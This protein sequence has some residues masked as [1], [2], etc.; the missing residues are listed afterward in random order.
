MCS[1]GQLSC[2]QQLWPSTTQSSVHTHRLAM[3]NTS[4]ASQIPEPININ[5]SKAIK[6]HGSKCRTTF[7]FI[8]ESSVVRIRTMSSSVS[9]TALQFS[10]GFPSVSVLRSVT[11]D[12]SKPFSASYFDSV[13]SSSS[14]NFSLLHRPI[15]FGL[16]QLH[17]SPQRK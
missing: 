4:T 2:G 5:S 3:G 7:N 14:R 6:L 13:A 10:Y 16:R 1:S 17:F 8:R 15:N 12:F 11:R 9:V